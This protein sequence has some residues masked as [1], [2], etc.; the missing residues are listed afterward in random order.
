MSISELPTGRWRLQIRR[1]KLQFDRIYDTQAEAQEAERQLL[2]TVKTDS[3]IPTL[4]E[5]WAIYETHPDY[6]TKKK[7]TR[8]TEASRIKRPLKAL[9]SECVADIQAEDVEDYISNRLSAKLKPSSDSLRL[10]IAAL[11]ALMNFCRARKWIAANPCTGVKK[12]AGAIK[13]RRMTAEEE[14]SLIALLK[15]ENYRFRAAARLCLLVRETGARPG[16]WRDALYRD[17]NMEQARIVFRNTKYRGQPRTVPLTKTALTLLAEQ[18]E[19]VTIKNFDTFGGTDLI[20]PAV[21]LDGKIRP[22]HYTGALRDAKKKESLVRSIRAHTGRHEYIS[23]LVE[24]TDMDDS[25]IMALVGHHSAASMEVYKH[26]RNIRFLPQLESIEPI[27]RRQRAKSLAENLGIPASVVES[28]LIHTRQEDEKK[29]LDDQGDELLYAEQILETLIRAISGLGASADERRKTL[30]ARMAVAAYSPEVREMLSGA[31]M[32]NLME[33]GAL[34]AFLNSV[35]QK[36]S[37]PAIDPPSMVSNA[38]ANEAPNRAEITEAE[39]R[40]IRRKN[41]P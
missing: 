2:K 21:G 12:P 24:S 6:L 26:V 33:P 30:L 36:L 14:G 1:R 40:S 16:E 10:E 11:S 20:F 39:S 34:D 9:G 8:D 13:P 18:L 7:R 25:R 19:D 5:A 17:L 4:E 15:H 29:G 35:D 37:K 28:L 31:S 22:M 27:R 41:N 3:G 32:A 38:A 23:T